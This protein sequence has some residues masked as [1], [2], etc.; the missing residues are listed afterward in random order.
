MEQS[1]FRQ[2]YSCYFI[3]VFVSPNSC[4][5]FFDIRFNI[6]LNCRPG[7]PI[8]YDDS[9]R[10]GRSGNRISEGGDE[11]FCT[12]RDR[13]YDPPSLLENRV[14]VLFLGTMAAWA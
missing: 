1:S 8:R 13:H 9:V 5:T 12:L 14:P 4:F 3:T 6:I 7:L 2:A 10:A 11:V